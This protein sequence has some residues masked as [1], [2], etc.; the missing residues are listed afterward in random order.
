MAV[1]CSG[2]SQELD[3]QGERGRLR[4][5]RPTC[6]QVTSTFVAQL[7]SFGCP[8]RSLPCSVA[9]GRARPPALHA[10]FCQFPLL[11]FLPSALRV[12]WPQMVCP[13]RLT[14]RKLPAACCGRQQPGSTRMSYRQPRRAAGEPVTTGWGAPSLASWTSLRSLVA[15]G[16]GLWAGRVAPGWGLL[17]HDLLPSPSSTTP[18]SQ[19]PFIAKR[20]VSGPLTTGLAVGVCQGLVAA[21]WRPGDLD[22]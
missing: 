12:P 16:A 3:V 21:V 19:A 2:L 6:P 13:S 7:G 10:P 4:G 8:G 5:I 14:G 17:P 9:A 1:R 20:S 18:E 11:P 15:K 22:G